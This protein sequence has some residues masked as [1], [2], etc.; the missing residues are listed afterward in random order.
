M[1]QTQGYPTSATILTYFSNQGV[2]EVTENNADFLEEYR[3]MMWRLMNRVEAAAALNVYADTTTT[4]TVAPGDY[5]WFGERKTYA[6]SSAVNPTD[7]D[8]T[9]V[10]MEGDNTIG[11][12]I[13]GIGWPDE[14]HIRLAEI[15]VNASGVITNIEDM[16]PIVR[17]AETTNYSNIVCNNNQVVCNNNNVVYT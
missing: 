10:W 1:A 8:T 12:A 5:I 6:G 2:E 15:T 9:Y 4:F 16:R 17:T 7:D 11:Y 13:D 3:Q 14:D